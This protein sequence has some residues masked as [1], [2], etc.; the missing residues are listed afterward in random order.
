MRQPNH[1][2]PIQGTLVIC[3]PFYGARGFG[4]E[5]DGPEARDAA[6]ECPTCHRLPHIEGCLCRETA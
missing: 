6:H 3:E 2:E 4:V 1:S 5:F